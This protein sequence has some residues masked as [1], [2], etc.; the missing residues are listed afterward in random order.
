[1]TLH[2][3]PAAIPSSA[4]RIAQGFALALGGS[5]LLARFGQGSGSLLSG[6]ADAA[7]AR[8]APPR[9]G[10]WREARGRRCCALSHRGPGGTAGLCRRGRRTCLYGGA[11]RRISR[12]IPRRGGA[13]RLR[14]RP[15]VGP[16]LDQ[17]PRLA[18]SRPRR[19]VRLWLCLACPAHRRRRRR[20][21]RASRLSRS[22]RSS[23]P[24][25]LSR[26]SARAGARSSGCAAPKDGAKSAWPPTP[27]A[28]GRRRGRLSPAL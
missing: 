12:R 6:A 1:M 13:D 4:E 9:R 7:D 3:A 2:T 23:R 14:R 11:D 15:A 20:S 16:H 21:R 18:E 26:W 5:L 27:I 25:S 24:C 8:R 10:A 28:T 19:R 17:A 22:R